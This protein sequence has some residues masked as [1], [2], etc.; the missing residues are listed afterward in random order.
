MKIYFIVV[1]L[2]DPET[3]FMLHSADNSSLSFTEYKRRKLQF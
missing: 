1:V 3:G 2:I